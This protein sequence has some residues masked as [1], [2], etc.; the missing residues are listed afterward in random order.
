[1]ASL[2][3]KRK[4]SVNRSLKLRAT[5]VKAVPVAAAAVIFFDEHLYAQLKPRFTSAVAT[6]CEAGADVRQVMRALVQHEFND[7][8]RP[9]ALQMQ[10]Y[11][12]KYVG[13]YRDQLSRGA[14]SVA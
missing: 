5:P 13:D 14:P 10:P 2:S 4:T 12:V 7:G 1:M 11:I 9:G 8:G 6:T 3:S